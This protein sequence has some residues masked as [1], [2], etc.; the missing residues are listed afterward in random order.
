MPAYSWLFDKKTDFKALTSK[1]AVQRKI[2]VPYPAMN[3]HEINDMA[4]VQAREIADNLAAAQV[5][6]PGQEELSGDALAQYLA[7]RE[8]V[9]LISYVQKIGAYKIVEP[10]EP[11]ETMPLDPDSYRPKETA[12]TK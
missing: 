5:I 3:Q 12:G 1:I 9:A 2:G 4:R 7:D 10:E 11:K 6:L 8:I